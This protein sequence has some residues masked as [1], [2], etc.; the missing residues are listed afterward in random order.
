MKTHSLLLLTLLMGLSVAVPARG[1]HIKGGHS[2]SSSH[3]NAHAEGSGSSIHLPS[4]RSHANGSDSSVVTAPGSAASATEEPTAAQRASMTERLNAE[5]AAKRAATPPAPP[6]GQLVAPTRPAE[7]APN[8]QRVS[9]RTPVEKQVAV[10][11]MKPID[12]STLVP[13][14][15]AKVVDD[16]RPDDRYNAHGVNCSL[17]PARC[18]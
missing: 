9:R 10:P 5:L 16:S 12:L 18:G 2:H 14:D 6:V 8:E 4:V 11:P 3:A 1:L 13:K 15:S 17:Y 7:L